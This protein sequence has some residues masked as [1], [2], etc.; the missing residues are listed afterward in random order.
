MRVTTTVAPVAGLLEAL[1]LLASR[2]PEAVD[3]QH[4]APGHGRF[5]GRRRGAKAKLSWGQ[6]ENWHRIVEQ[7]I[8]APLG[9]VDPLPPGATV[10]DVTDTLRY[11]MSRQPVATHSAAPG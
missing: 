7:R 9:G 1:A 4:V 2:D 11:L 5:R 10:D 3:D 8:W 6:K